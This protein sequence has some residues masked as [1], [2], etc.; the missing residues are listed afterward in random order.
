MSLKSAPT[1][2]EYLCDSD[3]DTKPADTGNN[4][5]ECNETEKDQYPEIKWNEILPKLPFDDE[6]Y[7]QSFDII[8]N[9]DD[10][11]MNRNKDEIQQFFNQYGVVVIRDVIDEKEAELSNSELFDFV[12]DSF[13]GLNRNDPST[14]HKIT[15]NSAKLGM[16]TDFPVMTPQLTRNR[17]NSKLYTAYSYILDTPIDNLYTN[18][19]RVGWMRPTKNIQF[20]PDKPREDRPEWKT[21]DGTTWL[22]LDYDPLTN[23]CTTF[24]LMPRNQ[25]KD[26]QIDTFPYVRTQGI[27][28]LDDCTVN[29]GGFQCV[30]GFHNIM[31]SVWIEQMGEDRIKSGIMGHR[32]Q[33]KKED[34]VIEYITKCP[35]RKGSFLVWNSKL[36]HNNFPND[37]D[38]GRNNQYIKYARYDDP[39]VKPVKFGETQIGAWG[40]WPISMELPDEV[41][42][43]DIT[44][45]IYGIDVPD[46]D[47]TGSE[48]TSGHVGN[49]RFRI[50]CVLL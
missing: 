18:I 15:G 34:P 21:L 14:W 40:I 46:P 20:D 3:S 24:G 22:H 44:R 2:E 31:K 43:N 39:A 6:G 26:A 33:F 42:L 17:I 1:L 11:V 28:A 50:R 25:V 29:D 23:H 48:A 10:D 9:V 35:I 19:G 7:V 45:R 30:P 27:L 16:I 41:E 5:T 49:S 37:S 13:K 47:G 4:A 36:P 12:E 32:Y 8:L 38:H